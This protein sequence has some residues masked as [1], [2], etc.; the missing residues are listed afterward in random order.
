M[1]LRREVSVQTKIKAQIATILTLLMAAIFLFIVITINIGNIA[2]NKTMVSNASDGAGLLL[3]SMLGSLADSL[4][5][6]LQLYHGAVVSCDID[7]AMIAQIAMLVLAIAAVVATGGTA[8]FAGAV[9]GLVL[10]GGFFTLSMYNAL[11]VEPG[12][13]RQAELKFQRLTMNQRMTEKS[14]QYALFGV[15]TDPN[16]LLSNDGGK[17]LRFGDPNDQKNKDAGFI[18]TDPE[19]LDMNGST[20]N[21]IS[22]FGKWY[23]DRLKALP[24]LGPVIEDL[25]KKLFFQDSNNPAKAPTFYIKKDPKDWKVQKNPDYDGKFNNN[26]ECGLWID[27][28]GNGKPD[29]G[30]AI[31]GNGIDSMML[32]GSAGIADQGNN[33]LR[34]N[35]SSG[36][37]YSHDIYF[38]DWLYGWQG[39]LSSPLSGFSGLYPLAAMLGSYGYG[40]YDP[41]GPYNSV[42][43]T[44]SWGTIVQIMKLAHEIKDFQK[45][46]SELYGVSYEGRLDSFDQ[47][48][49]IFYNP[50]DPTQEDWYHHMNTWVDI[51]SSWMMVLL[52]RQ[53]QINRDLDSDSCAAPLYQC[54]ATT[55]APVGSVAPTVCGYKYVLHTCQEEVPCVADAD[56]NIPVGPCYGDV[57]CYKCDPA[58]WCTCGPDK[59][60]GGR[61]CL[62][63]SPCGG[64]QGTLNTP[65]GGPLNCC[66]STF[67][68]HYQHCGLI[69][70]C[71]DG[72][73]ESP[74]TYGSC[75]ATYYNCAVDHNLNY[76]TWQHAIDYLTQFINDVKA[77]QAVFKNAY[78]TAQQIQ[79][80]PRFYEALYEWDDKVAKAHP[81]HT[82]LGEQTV[83]HIA[84]VKLDK[85]SFNSTTT[86]NDIAGITHYNTKDPEYK[87]PYL[88][89]HREWFNLNAMLKPWDPLFIKPQICY[90]VGSEKGQFDI[91]VGRYDGDL[92]NASSTSPLKNFWTF[93]IRR[94]PASNEQMQSGYTAP[95]A[96]PDTYA[97][98][99]AF[100]LANGVVA[101]TRGHYGPGE[102]YTKVERQNLQTEAARRNRDIYIERLR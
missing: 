101:T 87:F 32:N 19:D 4:R 76:I 37:V 84:Y 29:L 8:L 3:A 36:I 31:N 65:T 74:C 93:K 58:T 13:M 96:L 14:I 70:G 102:T 39:D 7:F 95:D 94:N 46:V 85:S 22:C 48:I 44:D 98:K 75:C 78:D 50:T 89:T 82:T 11:K 17:T 68:L 92:A 21:C 27:T 10:S 2:Q 35:T 62:G 97:G 33:W 42:A 53:G 54:G 18:C 88:R 86:Y 90:S 77:L 24:S 12:V 41:L 91:T 55:A 23:N 66:Q 81:G 5:M 79:K 43:A 49:A 60:N 20:T 72:T 51:A 40:M 38:V 99:E 80:D 69:S 25:Y 9:I 64:P 28:N 52:T 71:Q 34:P 45:D 6:Q 30:P 57:D 56:G 47:W 26:L 1:F 73:S 67:L 100:V 61:L 59:L 63:D 15:V 16:K 83:H